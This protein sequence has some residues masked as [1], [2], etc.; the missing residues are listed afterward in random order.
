LVDGNDKKVQTERYETRTH[1]AGLFQVLARIRTMPALLPI[2]L[3]A[4]H[5]VLAADSMPKFDVERTCQPAAVAAV[6]PGRDLAACQRDE[7]D[8]RGKLEQD[9]ARYNAAQKRQCAGFVAL[10]RAPSYVELLTCLEMAKQ[11]Q[12]L[13]PDS[14]ADTVGRQ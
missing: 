6:L 11:A 4:S 1:A 7:R 8:A 12:E 13:P 3:T 14:K 9:W 10:D 2:V 5:L